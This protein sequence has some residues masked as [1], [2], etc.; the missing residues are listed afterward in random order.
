MQAACCFPFPERSRDIVIGHV[1]KCLSPVAI[2]RNG[3]ALA[4]LDKNRVPFEV[5]LNDFDP[6][7][8]WL[9]IGTDDG[10]CPSTHH[11]D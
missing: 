5:T 3:N 9:V 11:Q 4:I 2:H 1:Q 10:F 6:P 7:N 8:F